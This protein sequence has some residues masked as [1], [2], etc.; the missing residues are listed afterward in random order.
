[1]SVVAAQALGSS[2][3]KSPMLRLAATAANLGNGNSR[4]WGGAATARAIVDAQL[5]MFDCF[6]TIGKMEF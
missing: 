1:M 3:P 5:Q 4:C 2:E 6:S